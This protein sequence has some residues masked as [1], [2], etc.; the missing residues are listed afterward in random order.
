MD[1]RFLSEVA[2]RIGVLFLGRMAAVRPATELDV[3]TVVDIM[4]TGTS[5]RLSNG[6]Q[7]GDH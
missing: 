4:T 6:G 2:E 3:A 7:G 5:T 1:E